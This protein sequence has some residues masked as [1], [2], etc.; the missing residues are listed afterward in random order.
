MV[1]HTHE[2]IDAIFRCVSDYWARKKKCLTPSVFLQHLSEA[3]PSAIVH[4]MVE[5]V[6]DYASF[7]GDC[8][9]ET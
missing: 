4:P 1:G 8:I 6:H 3:I 9:Y 2:D 7:L 5:Y